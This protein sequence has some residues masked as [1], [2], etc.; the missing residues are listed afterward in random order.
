MG[1]KAKEAG[2]YRTHPTNVIPAETF[3]INKG[4]AG[5]MPRMIER[6]WNLSGSVQGQ[7]LVREETSMGTSMREKS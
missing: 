5:R 4:K 6:G 2:F 3:A 7:S 1:R